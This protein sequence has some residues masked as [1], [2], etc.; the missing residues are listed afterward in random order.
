MLTGA[1]RAILFS[2]N[3][4]ETEDE[5]DSMAGVRIFADYWN[6]DLSIRDAFGLSPAL[7]WDGFSAEMTSAVTQLLARKPPPRFDGM[8]VY[9]SFS[10]S[11]DDLLRKRKLEIEPEY[12]TRKPSIDGRARS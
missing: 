2:R 6:I 10:T 5:E 8:Q 4:E 1:R 7:E 9:G 3:P 12:S 11:P